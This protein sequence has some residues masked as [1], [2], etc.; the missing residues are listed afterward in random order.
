MARITRSIRARLAAVAGVAGLAAFGLSM[1]APAQA[2]S[3]PASASQVSS[4]DLDQH[5]TIN[6]ADPDSSTLPIQCPDVDNPE[7]AF[8]HYVGHDEPGVWDYSSVPGSGNRAK[9]LL[10]LPVDP[11]PNPTPGAASY[12]FEQHVAFWFG[13]DLCASQSYPE[14]VPNCNPD[15]DANILDP[16]VSP[17]HVGEAY[18]ELQFYPP[19]YTLMPSGISCSP[20]S[21]CAAAVLWSY[22]MDPVTGQPI[23][24]ACQQQI[25]GVEV[26]NDAFITLDGKPTGPPDPLHSTLASFT[27]NSDVLFMN[28]GDAVG[29][30]VEDSP[31]GLHIVLADQTSH[32]TGTMTASVANGFA[33]VNYAADPSTQCTT[34]PYAFHPMYSTSS[35]QTRTTWTAFPYNVAWS[36]ETGHFQVCD[37]VTNGRCTG[38][39]GLPGDQSPADEDD[40]GCTTASQSSLDPV[41][42]CI[43]ENDGFDGTSYVDDWPNGSPNRPTP[44][45]F[46]GPLTGRNFTINYQ[47]T[48][49]VAPMPFNEHNQPCDTLTG[50][51]CTNP[52][53]TDEG[54]PAAFYPYFWT[55]HQNGCTWGEGTD[56]PGVT[57][58]DFGKLA[59]YGSILGN[60]WYTQTGGG[61]HQ[62]FDV[63]MHTYQNNLCREKPAHGN[64]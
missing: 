34:T 56:V 40:T 9:W 4:A 38:Q 53:L 27:P 43:G 5:V 55:T 58:Q 13:M 3:Q 60:V 49:L 35:L 1:P 16:K 30:T 12:S 11:A 6:C 51:G 45:E 36:D 32:Q 47:R 14:Q 17:A 19:G 29:V 31:A 63:F 39:E 24:T 25:G 15:T 61:A 44:I 33:Q 26:P 22:Y 7:L 23:N 59:Q 64:G 20:T 2:A 8:G 62:R 54:T 28:Q 10:H 18:L 57:V 46:A 50:T 42:G 21:W 37:Q 52:P 41:T 48:A